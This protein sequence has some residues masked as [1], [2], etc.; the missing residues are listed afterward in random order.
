[1]IVFELVCD[2]EHRF[3]GWFTSSDDF[4]DQHGR[5]LLA[6]PSCGSVEVR[7]LLTAKIGRAEL[8]QVSVAAQGRTQAPSAADV[9][10]ILDHVLLNTEDVGEEF[11]REARRM[12]AREMPS[13]GIRGQ[14][15]V[16]ESE[17]LREEGIPVYA[18]PIPAKGRWN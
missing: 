17:S 16:E 18:L 14:A 6:C 5:G 12:H 1:M 7:K 3:E 9:S 8:P 10:A 2:I 15:R 13:R 11:A 4:D